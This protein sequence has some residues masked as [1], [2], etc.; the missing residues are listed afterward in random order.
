[1]YEYRVNLAVTYMVDAE[2]EDAALDVAYALAKNDYGEGFAEDA[3]YMTE[4][5]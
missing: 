2:D 4:E 1:M 5:V 3:G